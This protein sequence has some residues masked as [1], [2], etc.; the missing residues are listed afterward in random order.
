[1]GKN[2]FDLFDKLAGAWTLTEFYRLDESRF[3]LVAQNI[4][5]LNLE[6]IVSKCNKV[7][8]CIVFHILFGFKEGLHFPLLVISWIQFL[9]MGSSR[10]DCNV[11]LNFLENFW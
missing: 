9:I 4:S 8:Y 3:E 2:K 11:I 1:M 10:D 6:D 7:C 5:C